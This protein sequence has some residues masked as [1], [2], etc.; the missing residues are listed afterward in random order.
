MTDPRACEGLRQARQGHG[1]GPE[2]RLKSERFCITGEPGILAPRRLASTMALAG[3][4][5]PTSLAVSALHRC[6]V[7]DLKS[8]GA[9]LPI[10][11]PLPPARLHH[12]PKPPQGLPLRP[13]PLRR[14]LPGSL[15]IHPGLPAV[16]SVASHSSAE[17]R[18]GH[19]RLPPEPSMASG[20]NAGSCPAS[21]S[22]SP[23]AH[24]AARLR[25]PAPT[26][27]CPPL[28][29]PAPEASSSPASFTRCG[30]ITSRRRAAQSGVRRAE[31]LDR[32]P[33]SRQASG[34]EDEGIELLVVPELREVE[35]DGRRRR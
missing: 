29:L 7:V 20:P 1:C 35:A 24:R 21:T 19:D 6:T 28:S 2:A 14:P 18:P 27:P 11:R 13:L 16:A 31:L 17:G 5:L 25:P 8:R 33:Q 9:L 23:P 26:P 15:R 10:H 30:S 34:G 3:R 4:I 22:A 12:P 32:G